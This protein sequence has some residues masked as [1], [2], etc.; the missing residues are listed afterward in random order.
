MKKQAAEHLDLPD[1]SGA[2]SSIVRSALHSNA[3]THHP[4]LDSTNQIRKHRPGRRVRG[5]RRGNNTRGHAHEVRPLERPLDIDRLAHHVIDKPGEEVLGRVTSRLLAA[6]HERKKQPNTLIKAIQTIESERR[7]NVRPRHHIARLEKSP[8]HKDIPPEIPSP[9]KQHS[10]IVSHDTRRL[11]AGNPEKSH[12]QIAEIPLPKRRQPPVTKVNDTDE[13]RK[14]SSDA[15][16]DLGGIDVQMQ[17]W[18]AAT[19]KS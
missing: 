2:Q 4:V 11:S 9:Q 16:P 15:L 18:I 3:E 13:L 10:H 1:S 5:H 12:G 8:N 6:V 17:S 14:R 19:N 7:Q